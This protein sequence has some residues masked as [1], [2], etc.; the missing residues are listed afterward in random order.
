[1]LCSIHYH[2]ALY[3]GRW[4]ARLCTESL[5]DRVAP[6]G[7]VFTY[8]DVDDDAATVSPPGPSQAGRPGRW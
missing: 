1:M 7:I 4:R 2:G 8:T 5:V 3:R 6:A